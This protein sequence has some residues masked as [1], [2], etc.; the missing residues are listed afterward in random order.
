MVKPKKTE[1]QTSTLPVSAVVQ[2]LQLDQTAFSVVQDK[3]GQWGVVEVQFSLDETDR[4]VHNKTNS[5]EEALEQLKV[6]LGR[7]V[8]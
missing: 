1:E 7:K 6:V 2:P 8:F 3:D 5:R 4:F